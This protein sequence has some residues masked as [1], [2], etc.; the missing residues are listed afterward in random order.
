MA[1]EFR[2]D[3]AGFGG[4]PVARTPCLDTL[5]SEGAVFDCAVTP[6]PVC[7]PA[8]QCMATGKYPFRIQCESFH[9]DL[10]PGAPTFARW[11]ADH[12]YYTV[13]CGKLHH[14]GPDQMQGWLHRIGSDSAVHWPERFSGRNQ[15][16]RRAWRGAE[17]IRAA[18]PG[19]SPY[20]LHDDLTVHGACDFLRMQ[21]GG[22]NGL[23]DDTPVF[24]MVSLWQPHFPLLCEQELF[25]YYLPR[26]PVASEA[27]PPGHPLVGKE[28]PAGSI[29]HEDVRRATA[30][31]YGMVEATDR[32]FAR[33]IDALREAGQ[34]PADWLVVFTSDHGDMLGDHGCWQKRSFYEESVG[35]PLFLTGPGVAAG[36][37]TRVS[38]LVDIFPTLCALAGLPV[39]EDLDG[40][41]LFLPAEE[42]LS[43]LGSSHFMLRH[44]SWKFMHFGGEAP[45]QLF[46]LA[47]DP[48]ETTNR[49][50]DP[51]C[52]DVLQRMRSR[53]QN[54]RP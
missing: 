47:S 27:S 31:Y 14:R 38:N 41:S 50:A 6:S 51:S 19:V 2:R 17:D 39:P 43:Q 18:G 26:V 30:A 9:S 12:G 40:G 23:P 54:L 16:G 44:G 3:A 15:I 25:D 48:R 8:R 29:T 52:S 36:R 34:N 10:P 42:T 24:L 46:D 45:D 7:V 1:D 33:V 4:N 5:A 21:F 37:S 53:L 32:R 22:M 28:V 35:V 13:A 11:F 20:A 49:A